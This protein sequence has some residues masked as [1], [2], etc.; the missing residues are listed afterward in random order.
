MKNMKFLVM[1]MLAFSTLSF[2]GNGKKKTK[3][4]QNITAV[5]IK[6]VVGPG[7]EKECEKLANGAAKGAILAAGDE[8]SYRDLKAIG[9]M[10]YEAAYRACMRGY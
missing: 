9:D 4:T 1:L 10:M 6:K 2:A 7:N 8:Y 5:K 3:I